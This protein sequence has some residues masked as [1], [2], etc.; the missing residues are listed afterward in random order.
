MFTGIVEEVGRLSRRETI[1]NGERLVFGA[2]RIMQDLAL[3]DSIAV[4]GVCQTVVR[5]GDGWFAVEAVG[6]TLVKTSLGALPVGYPVNLERACTP[7]TRLGGHIVLGHV[8]GTGRVEAWTQAGE[9]WRLELS[10]PE[11]LGRYL[12]AE[13]SVALDG[14]SLT[15]AERMPGRMRLSI[16]PH[17]ASATTLSS[18]KPGQS[19][20]IEVDILAKYLESLL[21]ARR[22]GATPDALRESGLNESI[23]KTWGYS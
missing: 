9:A 20:N 12:V 2:A 4:N 10:F 15:I 21:E 7:S 17:T 13:G 1:A 11:A 19:M 23:L 22:D 3:G 14:I 8:N 5:F 6:D 18:L 16:I